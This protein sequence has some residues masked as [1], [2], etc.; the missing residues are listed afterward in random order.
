MLRDELIPQLPEPERRRFDAGRFSEGIQFFIL[1][2]SKKV[3][4]ADTLA[5]AVNFGYSNTAG[6]DSISAVFLASGYLA[7]LYFDFSLVF[8]KRCCL[9]IRWRRR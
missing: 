6:L 3:L 7:E 5:K 1:G 9:Q 4:L 2:L 8:P